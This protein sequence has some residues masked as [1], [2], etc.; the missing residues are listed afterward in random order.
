[1]PI[2]GL[3]LIITLHHVGLGFVNFAVVG[4][5]IYYNI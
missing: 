5:S 2:L 4:V 1:M 3:G